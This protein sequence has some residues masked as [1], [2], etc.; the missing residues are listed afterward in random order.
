MTQTVVT[1]TSFN[2]KE[3]MILENSSQAEFSSHFCGP[4]EVDWLVDFDLVVHHSLGRRFG[5]PV[6]AYMLWSVPCNIK[7]KKT[8]P[9][10]QGE[11]DSKSDCQGD[12]QLAS[13]WANFRYRCILQH[14]DSDTCLCDVVKSQQYAQMIRRISPPDGAHR[15]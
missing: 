15:A 5:V 8:M 7:N 2:V 12:C 6:M 10:A 14:G 9:G 4:G 13:Y 3:I 1:G 11:G